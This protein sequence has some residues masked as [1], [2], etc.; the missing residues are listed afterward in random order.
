MPP[1]WGC[2]KTLSRSDRILIYSF[3]MSKALKAAIESNDAT[4]VQKAIKR[5]KNL[6][7]RLPGAEAP[8]LHACKKGADKVIAVLLEAGATGEKEDTYAGESPFAVAAEH[9]KVAVTK[10]SVNGIGILLRSRERI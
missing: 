2:F 3:S 8:L 5:V 1:L 9:G 7:R 6:N 4:E 10:G